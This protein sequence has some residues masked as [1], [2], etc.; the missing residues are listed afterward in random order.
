MSKITQVHRNVAIGTPL[1]DD[2][3][4]LRSMSGTEQ[5]GRLFQFN[6]QLLS[7][8]HNLPFEGIIGQNVT[9][10]LERHQGGG[11]R[12]FN[13]YISRFTLQS[14][15][16][17]MA[18]YQ[19]T[20]VPWLWFLTRGTDCRIFQNKSVPD[21]IKEV[22]SDYG[23][24]DVKD[25][26]SASH[27]TW[28][29]CVQY[30]ET[31]FNFVSRLMEQEGIYFFFEHENG[32][33]T[34]VLADGA[35]AHNPCPDCGELP[36]R[37]DADEGMSVECVTDWTIEKQVLPGAFAHRDFNFEKPK[38]NLEAAHAIPREH[39][40]AEFEVYDYPGEYSET[41]EGDQY[42]SVRMQELQVGHETV[43]GTSN[44][45]GLFAGGVFGLTEHPREDQAREY[46]VTQVQHRI[47]S[48]AFGSG[49]GTGAPLYQ[50]SFRAIPRT[51]SFR[52]E[53]TTPKPHIAGAQTAM[54]TGPSGEEIHTDE[55]GRVKV[56]FHWDRDGKYD[57][58][59]SCWVRVSQNWAGKKWGVFFLPRIGQEVIVEF[60]EGDPDR[61]IITGRVYNGESKPPYELPGEKTKSTIKS[62]SSKDKEGHNELRFEDK[63]GEEQLY[64]HAE[65]DMDVRV[66][67]N[68]K[69]TNYGHRDIRVGWEKDGDRGG[70]YKI[71]VRNDENVHIENDQFEMVDND[72]HITVK[73]ERTE[74]F[75]KSQMRQVAERAV[76][77]TKDRIVEAGDS[78][79]QKTKEMFLQGSMAV[80][81]KGTK[82][83]VEGTTLSLKSGGS[84]VTI[85]PAG[86]DI[87]GPIV[88][89]NSGGSGQ[90]AVEPESAPSIE[91][92]EPF[93]ASVAAN[94]KGGGRARRRAR[95]HIRQG[96]VLTSI[97]APDYVAPPAPSVPR[98][99]KPTQPP[100]A[101]PPATSDQPCG[102]KALEVKC[103]HGRK[104]GPSKVL[105]IVADGKVTETYKA[106]ELGPITVSG[107]KKHG[108]TDVVQAKVLS[109]DGGSG[110]RKMLALTH[111]RSTPNDSKFTGGAMKKFPIEPAQTTDRFPC[112][113]TPE[114]SYI[115]GKGCDD[116]VHG[117]TVESFPNQAYN[118]TVELKTFGDW[119]KKVNKGWENWGSKVLSLSPVDWKPKVEG[120]QGKLSVAWGWEEESE[121]WRVYF[122]CSAR[123]ALDPIIGVGIEIEISLLKLAGA[124]FAIPPPIT[125]LGSEHI[126]DILFSVAN[127]VSASLKGT[128]KIKRFTTGEEIP[129]GNVALSGKGY[130]EAK[131]TARVGSKYIVQISLEGSGKTDIVVSGILGLKSTGAFLSSKGELDPLVFAYKFETR[132]FYFFSKDKSGDWKPWDTIE[133]WK[134][135]PWKLIGD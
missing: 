50:C 29:Y 22:F 54:V 7:E 87:S 90:A 94:S 78:I 121:D 48:D 119:V 30:R 8:D 108:G 100:A 133:L 46:L 104:P 42:A 67:N 33:H 86:V 31:A 113:A 116:T 77:N 32:K 97:L 40:N 68:F 28:E 23:F 59:S 72:S 106:S 53:R 64:I 21:I 60:L 75:E 20:M 89:I 51:E 25:S 56:Q 66:K 95:S 132:A 14:V 39:A 19:A 83:H 107:S 61:P 92:L 27:R 43:V 45:R 58:N 120:P 44:A 135:E 118:L 36:F 117:I 109:N 9:V 73:G 49:D 70:D 62:S 91:V 93:D 81:I 24:T 82:I 12:F 134:T 129:E 125:A 63:A 10:R 99:P 105:Q 55:H 2:V 80:H 26:L 15:D 79:S 18:S 11:A 84:F 34:L 5:I 17:E 52:S 111:T 96:G 98:P 37:S 112:N 6:L 127:G 74:N 124:A 126:A 115:H 38:T 110:G 128:A 71:L 41:G 69:E 65:K 85:S 3:L 76:L 35:A 103:S 4:L 131:L 88:K 114:R 102:I 57:E 16:G 130:L 101:P 13:G 123:A 47:V 1:G 122:Q